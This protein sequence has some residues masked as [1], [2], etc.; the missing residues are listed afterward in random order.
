MW[1]G[2]QDLV[3][4]RE[5]L[6][7]QN[8]PHCTRTRGSR[9]PQQGNLL[10]ACPSTIHSTSSTERWLDSTLHLVSH[11]HVLVRQAGHGHGHS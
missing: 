10:A 9:L 7:Q 3:A 5:K 6:Q 1:R 8:S 4:G 11:P 2:G